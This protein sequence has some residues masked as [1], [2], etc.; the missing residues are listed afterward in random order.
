MF[1]DKASSKKYQASLD[2]EGCV[3]MGASKSLEAK[4]M[5]GGRGE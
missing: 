1:D 3:G 2:E 5:K 4:R